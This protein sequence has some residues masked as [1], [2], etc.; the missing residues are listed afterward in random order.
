MLSM[1]VM[2]LLIV[3]LN[4]YMPYRLGNLLGLKSKK[5]LY[6]LFAAGMV[7]IF[8]SMSLVTKFGNFF[9]DTYYNISTYWLGTLLF[10]VCLMI[11]FEIFNLFFK[12]PPKKAAY[13]IIT[14]TLLIS[15]YASLNAIGFQTAYIEIPLKNITEEVRIVQISDVHLGA[16]RGEKYLKK[17]IEKTNELNPDFVVITGDIADGKSALTKDMFKPLKQISAPAFFVEG[18]HDIYVGIDKIAEKLTENNIRILENEVIE[19]NGI[20][21]IG[22]KYMKADDSVYDP[23]QVNS[24]TIKDTL[25]SLDFSGDMP[26]IVIH[27]GPWGVEYLNGYGTDLIIAG[28]THAGQI[29]PATLLANNRFP[30]IKGLKNYNGTYVYVSQGAGTFFPKMRLGT[31]NEINF[32]TLKPE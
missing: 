27:H 14:V 13:A 16:H 19:I 28:H 17:I 5:W 22:L 21:L 25:P 32:I 12:F 23:H 2:L 31:N 24:E 26:K 10:L 4:V 11:I 20:K 30:Y 18:N 15:A 29:F 6:V 8:I 3:G 1:I 9:S 7:S